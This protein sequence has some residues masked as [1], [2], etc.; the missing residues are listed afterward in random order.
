VVFLERGAQVVGDEGGHVVGGVEHR[1]PARS[2]NI[3][4]GKGG[5][6]RG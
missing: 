4:N 2:L 3:E 1:L 5:G 6:G